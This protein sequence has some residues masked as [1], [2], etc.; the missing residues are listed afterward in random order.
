MKL[1]IEKHGFV[2]TV[3]GPD[4][5]SVGEIGYFVDSL[6]PKP[7]SIPQISEEAHV[8]FT[9][10]LA[11]LRTPVKRGRGRPAGSPNKK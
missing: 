9:K 11:K 8:L 3:E 7:I 4:N 6:V 10:E 2:V 1:T 5:G